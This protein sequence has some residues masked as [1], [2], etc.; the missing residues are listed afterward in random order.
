[1]E[2][3]QFQYSEQ[4]EILI[5]MGFEKDVTMS[6]LTH[7]KGDISKV[8][9][10]LYPKQSKEYNYDETVREINIPAGLLNVGNSILFISLLRQFIPTNIL[11]DTFI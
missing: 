4:L 6:A 9:N 10:K 3:P 7:F 11:Y 8:I 2:D 5:D 1:M